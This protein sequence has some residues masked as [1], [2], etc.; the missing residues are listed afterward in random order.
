MSDTHNGARTPGSGK[1]AARRFDVV[2]WGA[3]GFTGALVAEYLARH[4]GNGELRWAIAGRSRDKLEKVRAGLAAAAPGAA[5]LPILVGDSE[6]RA[7]LDAIARDASVVV[8]T[9]GP[10]ALYGSDL[11]AACVEAG[12]DYCDLTGE[13]QFIRRMIDKHHAGARA[14]G[15]R[16]VHCCG[17]DSIPS[18]L[19]TLMV[20]THMRERHGGPAA[21]VR[22]SQSSNGFAFS[23]GTVASMLQVTKEAASDGRVRRLLLDPYSLDPDHGRGGRDQRDQLGVRWDPDLK[24]WT[25]P[26]ALAATNARV[27]RRSNALLGYPYG[28][29]FRYREAMSTKGGAGGWLQA[30]TMS[31]GTSAFF[32]GAAVPPVRWLL[33]K[34]LPAPGEGPS[35]EERERGRFTTRFVAVGEARDG[36]APAKVFGTVRGMQDPGYGETAKMLTESAVCLALD[37]DTTAAAG[38]VL[39]PGSCMGMRLVE[40]LRAAGMTFETSEHR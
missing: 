3:T 4:Y 38:G 34:A 22:C 23:G 6:D 28:R 19:G 40:R 36:A 17:F 35:K 18:D 9:V 14:S 5:D 33:E 31:A 29:D 8:S 20:Q 12:A 30:A 1:R 7:S 11:V 2:L 15:A 13:P 32:T 39:T 27:V 10:Y 24:R 37:A 26:F 21:E 16:I 25:G